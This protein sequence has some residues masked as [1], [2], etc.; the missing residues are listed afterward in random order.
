MADSERR[1]SKDKS[2]KMESR[3]SLGSVVRREFSSGSAELRGFNGENGD[4]SFSCE[5]DK[6]VGQLRRLSA[7][8]TILGRTCLTY[9]AA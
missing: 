9:L 5:D 4:V 1:S 3:S 2:R 8:I 7:H 6:G